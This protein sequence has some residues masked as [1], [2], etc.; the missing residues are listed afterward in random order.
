MGIDFNLDRWGQVK[1]TCQRWWA[2]QLDRPII[3]WTVNRRDPGREEPDIP[4]HGFTAFY[5]L[6][7]PGEAIVDRWDYDLS[8]RT[9]LGDSFPRVWPNFGP[10]VLAAF[11]GADL[12]A[13]P[14][15]RTV[16]FHAQADREIADIHF[17]YD[18]ANVWLCRIEDICRAAVDR[19][20]PLV[21]VAMTDLG[22]NLDILS[23][24]RPGE[25]LLLDLTDHPD[26]VTRV[27]WEAHDL[28][29]RYYARLDE[30]LRPTNPGYSAWGGIYSPDPY[31]MLQCDFAYMI[32]PEMFDRFVRPE[33]A[34]TCGKLT[35][36][37][38]HLDG[39]GQL[40]HLDSLLEIDDL[41][42]VQ[43]I[44]G[45]GQLQGVH[46]ADVYRRIAAGGKKMQ[47]LDI[48]TVDLMAAEGHGEKV[49]WCT[50]TAAGTEDQARTTLRRHGIE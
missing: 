50:A 43:W 22:G 10:G 36:S 29:H 32:S 19:W 37:F 6:S 47:V 7:T 41:N 28:W 20:G 18:P 31:Y 13:T 11:L 8:C 23:T 5:D 3:N 12:H 42:G 35:H 48:E 9:F 14:D 4:A 16:W 38:Y 2:G 45:T 34:A 44:P 49:I 33:L 1:D 21:Q 27:L 30:I 17:E 15:E 39:V 40:G 25:K 24:F 46:W 26:E